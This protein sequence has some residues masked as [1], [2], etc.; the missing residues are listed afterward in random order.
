MFK[1]VLIIGGI[2]GILLIDA[3]AQAPPPWLERQQFENTQRE[4]KRAGEIQQLEKQAKEENICAQPTV[5]QRLI[6]LFN[7]TAPLIKDHGK[8]IAVDNP[9]T[10]QAFARLGQLT[11]RGNFHFESGYNS[12]TSFTMPYVFAID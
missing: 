1:F 4:Q 12:D 2:L 8:L 9:A 6:K 7:G 10:Q 3:R 11:C 5:E